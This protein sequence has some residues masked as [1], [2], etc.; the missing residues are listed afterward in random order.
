MRA[1]HA[2]MQRDDVGDALKWYEQYV[3]LVRETENARRANLVLGCAAEA[4]LRAGRVDEAARIGARRPSTIAEFAESPHYLG[5]A[6]RVQGQIARRAGKAAM[7]RCARSIGA[8]DAVRGDRQPARTR[9][10]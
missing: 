5:I 8:I 9:S 2:A 6:M 1:G 4:F 10:R 3:P 7:T